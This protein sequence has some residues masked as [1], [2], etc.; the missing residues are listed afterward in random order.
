MPDGKI[1]FDTTLDNKQLEKKLHSVKKKIEK[2]TETRATAESKKLPLLNEAKELGARLEDARRKLDALNGSADKSAISS[3]KEE[4]ALLQSSWNSVNAQIERYDAKIAESDRII[5]EETEKAGVL[6]QEIKTANAGMREMVDAAADAAQ[7]FEKRIVSLAKRVFVFQIITKVLR[8]AREYMGGLLE[9][10]AEYQAE[11]AKL[12]GA[13]ATAF[14]PLYEA[15]VPVLITIL[16]LLTKIAAVAARITS[17]IFGKTAKQSAENAKALNKQ[18]D[19]LGGVSDAADDAKKSLAG[20]D[21]INKLDDNKS[22]AAGGG[23][24][25]G[26]AGMDFSDFSTDEYMEK[27]QEFQVYLSGALLAIGAILA[28][29]GIN[30]PLGI[31]LMALGALGLAQVISENWNAMDS[32][33]QQAVTRAL[34]IVGSSLLALGAILALTGINIPLGVTLMAAGAATLYS[35]AKINYNAFS[36]EIKRSLEKIQSYMDRFMSWANGV[37]E[38]DWSDLWGPILG[39]S[40][41]HWMQNVGIAMNGVYSICSGFIQIIKGLIDRDWSMVWKG[42]AN[43]VVGKV[44]II[45]AVLNQMIASFLDAINFMLDIV[46]GIGAKLGFQLSLQ[47]GVPQ[48]PP[49]PML[50]KG[51]VIPP[52]AP[53]M[54]MLGDQRNGTNIETPESLLRQIIRE[55]SGNSG[56]EDVV[57]LLSELIMAVQGIRVGDDVIG[58][59]ATRY[60]KSRSRAT[61]V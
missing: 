9:K 5:S 50:A 16:Q 55:E 1:T 48:I 24:G 49:I 21:E 18:A 4:I 3:Q 31:S 46:N 60:Q 25:G 41:N 22:S 42:A 40:V 39:K 13:L 58:R 36:D 14:Q 59:A 8:A 27:L 61:G 44:N 23:G 29:S 10:N 28:F 19:A 20:F 51:A 35:A 47:V 17:W 11:L 53:F 33:L 52:N 38:R 57:R 2:A 15:A 12:K 37:F 26:A 7:A 45:I 30:V 32:P 6:E 43:I 56:N 54:A 34:T